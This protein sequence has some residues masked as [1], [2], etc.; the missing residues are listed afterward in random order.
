MN[1]VLMKQGRGGESRRPLPL[2]HFR[3]SCAPRLRITSSQPTALPNRDDMS[4]EEEE[5]G[6][7]K[8]KHQESR[9]FRKIVVEGREG[10]RGGASLAR[11]SLIHRALSARED[12]GCKTITHPSRAHCQRAF[13]CTMLSPYDIGEKTRGESS[14]WHRAR[15]I[16]HGG[17]TQANRRLS[18]YAIMA[19]VK[20]G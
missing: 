7:G 18:K 1:I 12:D 10:G 15:L 20:I 13:S 16:C 19:E 17:R 8:L 9:I 2:S 5:E 14:F 3:T 4:E 6:K 11:P